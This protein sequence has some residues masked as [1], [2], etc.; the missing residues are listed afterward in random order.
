MPVEQ[1]LTKHFKLSE[2]T[3]SKKAIDLGI[4]NTPSN[5]V[6]IRLT[7]LAEKVLEPLRAHF[8]LPVKITSGFRCP[9]LNSKV[10]GSNTSQHLLG[11][12]ADIKIPGVPNVEVWKY[13]KDN[14]P[15]DQLIAEYLRQDDD[16]AGWVH[17]SLRAVKN[18]QEAKS[19]IGKGRY[20]MG[21]HF[22]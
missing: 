8:G 3:R 17:V 18:R 16:T 6:I 9:A 5:D 22:V 20:P 14:L 4:D 19:C 13:I 11:E 2:F 15:Y 12:A 10:G 1:Q 7:Q 21:L